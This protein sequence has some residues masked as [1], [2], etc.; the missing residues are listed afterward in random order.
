MK[1]SAAQHRRSEHPASIICRKYFF[2]EQGPHG[3]RSRSWFAPWLLTFTTPGC[4][5]RD[6]GITIVA[7]R[8]ADRRL[9]DRCW[10]SGTA[11]QADAERG[12]SNYGNDQLL[13]V[14]SHNHLHSLCRRPEVA[15]ERLPSTPIGRVLLRRPF[16]DSEHFRSDN[17]TCRPL[18]WQ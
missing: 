14:D 13:D 8:F 1:A 3:G 10:C 5:I 9:F 2:D 7:D 11:N 12:V 16:K 17:R 4:P 18:L 15:I 6:N